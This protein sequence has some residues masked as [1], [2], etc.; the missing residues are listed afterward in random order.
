VLQ[1]VVTSECVDC[2]VSEFEVSL[3]NG[4]LLTGLNYLK[5]IYIRRGIACIIHRV[6]ESFREFVSK[7]KAN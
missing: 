1:E 7:R 2:C 4:L 5:I 3:A 6:Y